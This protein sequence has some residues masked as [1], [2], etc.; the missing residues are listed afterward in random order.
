M[1]LLA[2][3]FAVRGVALAAE[4]VVSPTLTV[5]VVPKEIV[6]KRTIRVLVSLDAAGV[7]G[8]LADAAIRLSAPPGFRADPA[9]V[10]IGPLSG[11]ATKSFNLRVDSAQILTGQHAALI[12]V[13]VGSGP[14]SRIVAS[15]S[16][17][18]D[19]LHEIALWEYFLFGLIGICLGYGIRL[20]LKARESVPAPL[21]APAEG[22]AP[23][24]VTKFVREHYYLAD[25]LL[26]VSL[27]LIA[28]AG[29]AKVGRPPDA[30]AAWYAAGV[31]GAGLGVLTNNE[32]LKKI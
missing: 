30:A 25:F 12:E 1:T 29:L 15:Q 19:Y 20:I 32:L 21:P 5:Q 8:G 28:L 10:S 22:E 23:G 7:S 26:T 4:V 9:V 3:F 14:E 27:G 13:T 18:V 16:L 6:A 17:L 31:L 2:I 24:P 11:R